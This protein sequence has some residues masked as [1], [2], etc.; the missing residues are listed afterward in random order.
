VQRGSS[1]D[2]VTE[3]GTVVQQVTC[4]TASCNERGVAASFDGKRVA[5]WRAG[6]AAGWELRVFESATPAN[7]RTV[8][9]L[10]STFRGGALAWAS[11][12]QGVLYAAQT[13][14]NFPGIGGGP[15]RATISAVDL[16]T[17]QAPGTDVM[18][19]RTEGAVYIP[20]AWDRAKKIFAAALTGEGGFIFEYAVSDASGHRA[21][22]TTG[23]LVAFSVEGSP[24]AT[25]VLA[26]GDG[27]ASVRI[28][29]VTNFAAQVA[30]R[31]PG[32]RILAARWRTANEVG[33]TFGA[34]FDVF[35]PQTD[36]SRTVFT[37]S[38]DVRLLAFR[39]D[40]T[41]ALIAQQSGRLIVDMQTGA[42]TPTPV[43]LAVPFAPRGVLLR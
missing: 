39:P 42:T 35:V 19:A 13:V 11:D 28:W 33:W 14:E 21:T 6:Q 32:G 18:P 2:L 1:F 31:P 41:G 15:R 25:R 34:R 40:G 12:G 30:V 9:T 22:R 27:L 5:H 24:D 23:E 29:P 37:G 26:I 17:P 36:T 3:T 8:V 4:G 43:E 7:A 20:V 38:G 10:P 16:T